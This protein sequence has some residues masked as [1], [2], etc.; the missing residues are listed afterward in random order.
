[1]IQV[2]LYLVSST[3]WNSQVVY[4]KG[5]FQLQTTGRWLSISFALLKLRQGVFK[6]KAFCYRTK[7]GV[8]LPA[9]TSRQ[10]PEAQVG[11][12]GKRPLFK[13]CTIWE[14]GGLLSQKPIPSGKPEESPAT[15]SQTKTEGSTQISISLSKYHTLGATDGY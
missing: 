6:S 11:E 9:P 10:N 7:V 14:N 13:C 4:T 1:M 3:P 8:W 12:K 2:Q 5:R 15:L